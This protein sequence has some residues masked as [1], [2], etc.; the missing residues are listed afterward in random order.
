MSKDE[1]DEKGYQEYCEYE[2][3]CYDTKEKNDQSRDKIV[4]AIASSLFG[5]LL[6]MNDKI[7]LAQSECLGMLLKILIISNGLT[8]V[9]SLFSFYTANLAIDKNVEIFLYKRDERNCWEVV[10]KCLNFGYLVTTIITIFVLAKAL[11]EIF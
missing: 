1:F 7:P 3:S 6:A 5:L 2:K 10:T 11:C 9:L 8:L 4:I